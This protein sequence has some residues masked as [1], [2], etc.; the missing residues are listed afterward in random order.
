MSKKSKKSRQQGTQA[1][2]ARALNSYGAVLINA[3]GEVLLRQPTGN[4]GGYAWTFAK[5]RPKEGEAPTEA[6]LRVLLEKTGWRAEILAEIPG[7][8]SGTTSVT[9]FFLAERSGQVGE[10][11]QYTSAIRWADFKEAS[12]LIS[13]TTDRIG[14]ERDL[15]LLRAAQREFEDLPFSRRPATCQD[16]WKTLPLPPQTA[17]IA[18]GFAYSESEMS[19]IRKGFLP[20]DMDEKWFAWF[21]PWFDEG[22]LYLHRS[23]TGICIFRVHFQQTE[24]GWIADSIEVNRDPH[25]YGETDE[26]SDHALAYDVIQSHLLCDTFSHFPGQKA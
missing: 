9:K 7:V 23:W 11:D 15:A 17:D 10:P 12:G 6:A 3:Q 13:Q 22:A 20:L 4:F 25:Q 26:D 2:S 18:A 16:D 1:I 24:T 8:F 5:G 19:S 14:Q 21:V